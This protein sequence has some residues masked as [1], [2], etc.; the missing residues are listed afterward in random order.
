MPSLGHLSNS[1]VQ[2][3]G[4]IHNNKG[5]P[6]EWLPELW[7]PDDIPDPKLRAVATKTAKSLCRSCPILDDCFAYALETNQRHGIWGATEPHER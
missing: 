6:C 7:F 5:T 2:L 3:L 1:Y 4:K